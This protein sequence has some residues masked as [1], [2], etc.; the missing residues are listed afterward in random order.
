VG[1]GGGGAGLGGAIFNDGGTLT[2]TDSTFTANTAQGG[3]AGPGAQNG[4]GLGGA[5]FSRN[6]SV[7]LS[8]STLS[9]N[10]AQFGGGLTVLV[11][12][13]TA[14]AAVNN[15]ALAGTPGGTDFE[16][17]GPAAVGGAG[18]LIQSPGA[19]LAAL[20]APL[21]GVA[22]RLGPLQNNGG[23][24]PTLRPLA[25]SPVL[26]AGVN[27]AVPAG[28]TTDQRGLPRFVGAAVDIGAVE[29][30]PGELSQTAAG[31]FFPPTA[32]WFLRSSPSAG[33]PDAGQ[34]QYGGAGWLPAVGDWT[35]SGHSGVGVFDPTSATWFLRNELGAGPPDAG[36]F[37]YGVAGW[38]PV[39]GDWQGSGHAGVGVFDP[40]SATW[41]LRNEPG[42]GPPDAGVFQYGGAG[43]VPVVGDWTGTGHLGIGVFD[44]ATATWYLRS[45][46]TPGAP[47]AGVFRYGGAGWVPVAGDWAGVGRAGVGAFDP[48]SGT[49]YLRTEAGAGA[50]DA[51]QF[52]YGG[53]GFLP[54]VGA[55]PPAAQMLLAAD[56]EGPGAGPLGQDQLQAAVAGALARLSA[57]GV[58]PG[59]LQALA[60]A[61]FEVS[62]L[63][64]GVLG[65]TDT[66][67]DTVLIS[68]DAAG[69]GW[70]VDGTPLA[71][72]EYAPG[73]PGSPLV[74][75][76]GSPAAGREDLL[77][78]VLH[79]MGHLAGSPDG[80]GGLMAGALG[81]GTRNL[82]ALEQVFAAPALSASA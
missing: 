70:F 45:S 10:A 73:G 33:P 68:G 81:L 53:P 43:W 41:F 3:S 36:S 26:N 25:G 62:V 44:P 21:T 24:T 46:A 32:A 69:H 23:P 2:V 76:A 17:L 38:L 42:A 60:A 47:D 61:H 9:G 39:V 27:S 18:D 28:V 82:G 19:G 52:A 67:T 64:D 40:A 6:G 80:G 78:T 49:W 15:T 1:G 50:P 5:I 16:A 58:G 11:D 8:S 65:E 59:L 14:T 51:G 29:V 74:A 30:Q 20:S 77:T 72:E 7:L 56:G 63:P 66:A 12:G 31:V 35:G 13:G 54:V 34:F 37:R 71:D 4:S 57:A 79:E 75:L 48:G 55:F 22:A